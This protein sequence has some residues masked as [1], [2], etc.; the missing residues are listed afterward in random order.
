MAV[1][2]FLIHFRISEVA[3][4]FKIDL[5]L[6]IKDSSMKENSKYSKECLKIMNNYYN[7]LN[8]SLV[9]SFQALDLYEIK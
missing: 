6:F 9:K 2:I 3:A 8:L 7:D 5:V 4:E 1:S